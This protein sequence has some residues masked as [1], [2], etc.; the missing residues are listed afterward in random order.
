MKHKIIKSIKTARALLFLI[1]AVLAI[2]VMS[3]FSFKNISWTFIK[4]KG[5]QIFSNNHSNHA[6]EISWSSLALPSSD[7]RSVYHLSSDQRNHIKIAGFVVPLT[8][9]FNEINEFLLVPDSMS[10]I[11]VPPPPANQMILVRLQKPINPQLAYV[12]VWIFGKIEILDEVTQYGKVI[13]QMSG[14]GAELYEGANW[15][16]AKQN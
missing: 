9:N 2:T 15:R 6:T 8:D 14:T 16:T 12:P 3:V 13:Y 10:C 5:S 1:T 4:Q 7:S 11:H